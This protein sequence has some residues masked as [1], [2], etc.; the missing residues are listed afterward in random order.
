MTEA[1]AVAAAAALGWCY[2]QRQRSVGASTQHCSVAVAATLRALS[3]LGIAQA[4][5]GDLP[6]HTCVAPL[7]AR[8]WP[9]YLGY[10]S[11]EV[12]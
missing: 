10:L 4:A 11:G 9:D 3:V 12:A 8:R 1:V 6:P 2:R 5:W 7:W